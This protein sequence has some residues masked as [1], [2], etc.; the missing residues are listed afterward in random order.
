MFLIIIYKS[1]NN[2]KYAMKGTT[3]APKGALITHGNIISNEA[4]LHQIF[5]KVCWIA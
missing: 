3:G 5:I 1:Y 2:N 4:A